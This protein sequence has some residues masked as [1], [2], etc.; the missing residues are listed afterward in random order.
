RGFRDVQSIRREF[1]QTQ[2]RWPTADEILDRHPDRIDRTGLLAEIV[3]LLR[4]PA[5]VALVPGGE[6]FRFSSR[7]VAGRR[8]QFEL[9]LD[10]LFLSAAIAAVRSSD[11]GF[12]QVRLRFEREQGVDLRD[13]SDHRLDQLFEDRPLRRIYIETVAS[14]LG[15]AIA[16][17][18]LGRAAREQVSAMV[19]AWRNA[20]IQGGVADIMLAAY[21]DLDRRL[22]P[23]ES[24]RPVQT[25]HDSVVIECDRADAQA[26][27]A[28]VK[29]SLHSAMRRFCPDVTPRADVDVRTSLSESDVIAGPDLPAPA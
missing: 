9:H 8:Q 17:A 3:W 14:E 6:P 24:A 18:Y 19:N 20:P 13:R 28:E 26:V 22:R 16:H 15:S 2:G 10:R 11:T 23:I 7:T 25:V 4:Y 21:G 29:E 1:R 12:D 5:S 27:A